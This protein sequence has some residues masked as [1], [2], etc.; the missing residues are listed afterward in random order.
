MIRLVSQTTKYRS[1][2][3]VDNYFFLSIENNYRNRKKNIRNNCVIE[4]LP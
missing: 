2:S 4:T 3:G 1:F